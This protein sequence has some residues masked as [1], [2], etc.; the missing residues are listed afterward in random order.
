MEPARRSEAERRGEE[1]PEEGRREEE[2]RGEERWSVV[3]QLGLVTYNL[4]RDWDLATVVSRCA[5]AG[6]EGVELR[7][8]HAHGVEPELDAASRARVRRRFLESPVRLVG[9]GT[10]CEYH[11][12]D[13]TEVRRQVDAT[14]RAIDLAADVGAAG[15]KVRPNGDQEQAGVPRAQTLAQIGRA[16]GEC[17]AYAATRGV[18]IRLEMHGSVAGA[19]D[20]AAILEACGHP[21]VQVCWNCNPQDVEQGSVAASFARMRGRIGL[22]HMSE[23][24]NRGYPYRAFLGLLTGSGYDGFCLAEIPESPDPVRLMRYYRALWCELAGQD[25]AP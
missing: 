22:V 10:V 12:L 16:L 19:H 8:G 21:A 23:L 1:R 7:T 25:L 20:I 15:V 5:E 17:G 9:I 13:P 4:A 14:K 18:V 6:F 3:L 2:R 24:T 11:A